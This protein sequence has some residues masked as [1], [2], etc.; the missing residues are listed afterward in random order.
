MPRALPLLL[1]RVAAEDINASDLVR[2]LSTGPMA[3]LGLEPSQ[4]VEGTTADLSVIDPGRKWTLSP[5]SLISRG[6]NTPFLER[7]FSGRATFTVVAG[8]LVYR[9][10][11]LTETL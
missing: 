8:E 1:E 3:S 7:Q 10:P 2:L 6:K 5:A 11:A 9:A 4:L